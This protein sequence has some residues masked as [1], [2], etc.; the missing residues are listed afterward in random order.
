MRFTATVFALLVGL[1][2]LFLNLD[3]FQLTRPNG[4]KNLGAVAK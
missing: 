2:H 4:F 3:L 1:P